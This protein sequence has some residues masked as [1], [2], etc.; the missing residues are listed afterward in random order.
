MSSYAEQ[1]PYGHYPI[2][3]GA[4][5]KECQVMLNSFLMYTIPLAQE[6][7]RVV[8]GGSQQIAA[9]YFPLFWAYGHF[10]RDKGS[11]TFPIGLETGDFG[12]RITQ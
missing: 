3:S 2:G 7:V 5:S 10:G 8:K 1:F 6:R 4:K 12:E 9:A 11:K